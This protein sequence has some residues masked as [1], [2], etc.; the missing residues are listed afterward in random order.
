M[1]DA[2]R[3]S[4]WIDK[5]TVMPLVNVDAPAAMMIK[6]KDPRKYGV[7]DFCHT[8][9][10]KIDS[11]HYADD[12]RIEIIGDKGIIL[13]NRCTAKTIDLPELMLY[14]DGKTKAIP[15]ENV[16]WEDSFVKC[17]RHFIE[18]LQNGGNPLLDGKSG[19]AVLDMAIATEISAMKHQEINIC[20]VAEYE[21]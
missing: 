7:I 21:D 19:K 6:F 9:L 12:N 5:T 18:V 3:V 16:Q 20:D 11:Q 8:P 2:E 10:L 15:I 14:S 4:A 13:I 1:G 17:T